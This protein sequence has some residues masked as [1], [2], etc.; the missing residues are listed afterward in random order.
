MDVLSGIGDPGNLLK[1]PNDE[2]SEG[3]GVAIPHGNSRR[4]RN[5]LASRR[6]NGN[7][8]ALGHLAGVELGGEVA[9]GT[10]DDMYEKLADDLRR[11]YTVKIGSHT[12]F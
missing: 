6:P 1:K 3:V 5:R 4:P 2:T 10:V 12:A 8:H 7:D 9:L 11:N